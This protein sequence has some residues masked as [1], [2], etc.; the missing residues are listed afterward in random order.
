M[1]ET[2]DSDRISGVYPSVALQIVWQMELE[3][4]AERFRH[5]FQVKPLRSGHLYLLIPDASRKPSLNELRLGVVDAILEAQGK[6]SRELLEHPLPPDFKFPARP[7]PARQTLGN[8]TEPVRIAPTKIPVVDEAIP[9]LLAELAAENPDLPV[10]TAS[11]PSAPEAANLIVPERKFGSDTIGRVIFCTAK[12]RCQSLTDFVR[13]RVRSDVEVTRQDHFAFLDSI[14][15]TNPFG[16]DVSATAVVGLRA[17]GSIE[18]A[19]CSLQDVGFTPGSTLGPLREK[20]LKAC[21]ASAIDPKIVSE[22]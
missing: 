20:K 10:D 11:F 7:S 17:D 16:G 19:F 18:G 5:V 3:K 22:F 21:L 12:S 14:Y 6:F 1:D 13:Y 9:R 4:I 2:A 15:L 8:Y